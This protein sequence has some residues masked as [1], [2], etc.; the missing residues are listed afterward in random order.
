MFVLTLLLH[1]FL[2]LPQVDWWNLPRGA[3]DSLHLRVH[4]HKFENFTSEIQ[5]IGAKVSVFIE[6][7]QRCVERVVFGHSVVNESD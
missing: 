7:I 4:P 3:N 1:L 6:D 5:K 2:L